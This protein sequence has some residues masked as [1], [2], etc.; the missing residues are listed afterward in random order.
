VASGY[1]PAGVVVVEE[2][3][4]PT[5]TDEGRAILQLV[6]DIAPGSTL[7]FA[8]AF[9]GEVSFANNIL[10]LRDE[11]NADVI[12]DDVIYFN[13]P[14][15]SDGMVA[16]A[17]DAVFDDGAAYFSSAGNNGF[18]AYEATYQPTSFEAAQ[19]LVA[20]GTENL[21][22]SEIPARLQPQSFQTFVNRD[23]STTISLKFTTATVNFL[24]FQWDE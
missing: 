3:S 22:L 19:G 10:R 18:E 15:F 16:Q 2:L 13:E 4:D 8:S 11:F 17:V 21:I 7:G 24:S 1:L 14:M 12:V 6:H 20:A 23:G 5:G 9:N